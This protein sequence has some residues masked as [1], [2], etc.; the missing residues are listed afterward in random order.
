M[1]WTQKLNQPNW[2]SF[3]KLALVVLMLSGCGSETVKSDKKTDPVL[4]EYPVVFIERDVVTELEEETATQATFSA[5]NPII[6]NPGAHLIVK[7]N[8]FPD[9]PRIN[10]TEQLFTADQSDVENEDN[11]IDIRDLTVSEDGQQLLFSLRAPAIEDADEDEQP[12]WNIWH[13][14]LPTKELVR[15]IEND[16]TAEQGD[17]LMA[18]FLPDGRII[19]SSTRQRLSRAILL[20][21]GKP[22]YTARNERDDNAALNLHVMNADGSNI[23]QLTFNMSHDFY[24]LIL[25][26]GKILYSR[27]DSMGGNNKISLYAM[28]PDGTENQLIYGWHSQQISVDGEQTNIDF[29]KPQQLPSGEILILLSSNDSQTYQKKPIKINIDDF[30]DNQ[31]PISGSNVQ[32]S[33]QTDAFS[34]DIYDFNLSSQISTSG[35]LNHLY[36]L[37]DNSERFLLTWDICR[38]IVDDVL[39]GCGQLTTE[40]LAQEGITKAPPW[41]ELW[42]YNAKDNTHQLVSKTTEG[43]M[44]TEAVVMQ[45]SLQ[46][47]QY[48]ADKTF[49]T[50]LDVELANQQAASLHIRSVYDIDGED[51]SAG[52]ERLSDP[53]LTPAANLPARFLRIVR[54]VPMPPDDVRDVPNTDF[55]RSR[56]QLMREIIGYTPI[57]PDGSVKIKVPANVPFALSLLDSNGQRIGGRH[58]Q[59]ISLKAGETLECN[60][61]HQRNSQLPHGR[62]DAQ[63]PSINKGAIGGA[64]FTNANENIIPIQGQTMAEADAMVNGLA[65]PTADIQYSDL[66]TNPNKSSANPNINF[67]YQSLETAIPNGKECF[68]NWTAYCRIQINYV[69]HIQPLWELTRQVIDEDTAELIEDNTC[70]QCHR[71]YDNDSLAQVPAGQLDL[72]ATVSSDQA[73]HLTSY[74]ELFFNDVEQEVIEGIL[75]DK[76][77]ELLDGDGN[78]VYQVDGEGELILDDEENPIAV[79][80]TI[81]VSPVLSTNGARSS[82]NFLSLFRGGSHQGRLSNHELKLISEWLD[83]GGQYYNT[84]FHQ[85]DE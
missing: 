66:W 3:N 49:S 63:A 44:I 13:Y 32:G 31:Q 2:L 14:H 77:V 7:D 19:F 16:Y 75:V 33:A 80:T 70:T 28:N 48:I 34:S 62:M 40:E 41:Y 57:Q 12:T 30:I 4:V 69:E 47:R 65:Q 21:E 64:P 15:V 25:Q 42:L 1:F 79:L 35:D 20:D 50:G 73:A 74:R 5:R 71:L 17:D 11:R 10:L 53:S 82:N 45:E 59:W 18:S 6:F 36:P 81:P 22:Q 9:S 58:R 46:P 27:W 84:P 39:K 78:V 67:S 29:I 83:I 23:K 85:E 51:S 24:P 60:G 56:N 55:G 72:S 26:N 43:K 52:I 61:C 68:D 54:G 37:P 8:A 38:V 76:R